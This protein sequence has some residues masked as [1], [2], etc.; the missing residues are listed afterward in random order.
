MARKNDRLLE[1]LIMIGYSIEFPTNLAKR[2]EG[3]WDWNRH[4]M[5]RAI[6][7]GYVSLL[8]KKVGKHVLRSLHITEKGISYIAERD[9]K[10]LAMIYSRTDDGMRV[11]PSWTEKI[12]RYHA[13]ATGLIMARAAG[14]VYPPDEKPSLMALGREVDTLHPDP[15]TVYYYSPFEL[16]S[17]LEEK[18]DRLTMKSSRLIGVIIRGHRCYFMYYTGWTRMFWLQHAEENY[19]GGIVRHLKIRGFPIR[20]ISQIV[21]GNKMCIAEKLCHSPGTYGSRYFVVS[22]EFNSCFF[23]TNDHAGDELLRLIVDPDLAL[24]FDRQA[25]AGFLQ[26]RMNT[27]AY[28][29]IDPEGNRPVILNYMCDLQRIMK[30]DLNPFGY[31]DS[32]VMLCLDYQAQTIQHITGPGVEVRV[33]TGGEAE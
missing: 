6:E 10:A 25:L 7:D 11:Y 33:I 12:R 21:I 22:D 28:D 17:A 19:A 5:Y 8:R 4:I 18:E 26:P 3:H 31:N 20:T 14:A 24:R 16:R 30:I 27:R 23:V 29:A 15:D 2:I 32:P 9:P 1:M 13:I